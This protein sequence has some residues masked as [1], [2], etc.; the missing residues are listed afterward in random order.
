MSNVKPTS[1]LN[2]K[3]PVRA[4]L[5]QLMGPDVDG[6]PHVVVGISGDQ[7]RL[8]MYCLDTEEAAQAVTDAGIELKSV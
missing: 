1:H 2:Y 3:R 7:R 6:F 8:A 4:V 5:G